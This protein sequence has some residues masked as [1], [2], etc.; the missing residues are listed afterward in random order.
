MAASSPS[1]RPFA[2][3]RQIAGVIV[4]AVALAIVLVAGLGR[5]ATTAPSA[6]VDAHPGVT[7]HT[8]GLMRGRIAQ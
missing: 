3:T 2:G 1:T 6:P 7:D 4:A 8:P 5:L